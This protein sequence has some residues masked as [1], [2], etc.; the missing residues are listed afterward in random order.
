MRDGLASVRGT[1]VLDKRGSTGRTS[2]ITSS[3]IAR[4]A[5]GAGG[6]CERTKLCKVISRM[7]LASLP[8]RK[9]RLF[10]QVKMK[11]IAGLLF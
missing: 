7:L 2:A 11:K 3:S 1:V 10:G 9:H 8:K 5:R 6:E 4:V